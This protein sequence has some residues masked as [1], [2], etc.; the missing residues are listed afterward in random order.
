MTP[1]TTPKPKH[2][3]AA[4]DGSS[5]FVVREQMALRFSL[6]RMSDE[7]KA[8]LIENKI[9][10]WLDWHELRNNEAVKKVLG[11]LNLSYSDQK[12]KA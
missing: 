11:E 8:V 6:A 9:K 4:K 3:Q 10:L 5:L 2:R 7:Q 12:R 1:E